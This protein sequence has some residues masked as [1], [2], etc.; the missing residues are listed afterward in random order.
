[1]TKLNLLGAQRVKALTEILERKFEDKI[2]EI[3]NERMSYEDAIKELAKRK[4]KVRLLKEIY[5]LEARIK[6]IST[7]ALNDLGVYIE[8]RIQYQSYRTPDKV[9][10]EIED[11]LD[12]G[13][14]EIISKL[15]R[16]LEERKSRL[17]LVETLE[18]A[19]E[20]VNSE[21]EIR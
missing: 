10:D 11:I 19:Q 5:D 7:E 14:G 15:K 4:G 3:N 9:R 17:W 6:D 16:E 13:V 2:D 8:C 1:M 20:I 21:I 18:E 12:S